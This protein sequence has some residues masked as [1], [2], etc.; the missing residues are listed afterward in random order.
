MVEISHRVPE[1]TELVAFRTGHPSLGP[2]AF[3]SAAFQ[4]IKRQIK[5]KL[6]QDQSGLCAYCESRLNDD[7]GQVDHIKP[8]RGAHGHP[9]LTFVY[10]N[11]AHSCVSAKHCGQKRGDRLLPIEPRSG[12][13]ARFTLST[14]GFIDANRNQSLDEQ[15]EARI[16]RDLLGLNDP[17]LVRRRKQWLESALSHLEDFQAMYPAFIDNAPFRHTLKRLLS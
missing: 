17:D 1:P 7:D 3:D 9:N 14:D 6:H 4:P 8:R 15:Q 11:F 13:N 10:T 12:C 16:T 5:R 2:A